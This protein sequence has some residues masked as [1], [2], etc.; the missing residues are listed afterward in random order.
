MNENTKNT[1]K[2]ISKIVLTI[3]AYRTYDVARVI[4]AGFMSDGS[5]SAN[6]S[7]K[8][9]IFPCRCIISFYISNHIS[10]NLPPFVDTKI[11]LQVH[12]N[13]YERWKRNWV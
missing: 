8:S 3:M 13:V 5:P 6:Y 7:R 4:S 12:I 2:G 11:Y 1:L 9:Y 10:Y